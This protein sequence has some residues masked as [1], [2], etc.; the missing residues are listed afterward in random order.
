[1]RATL[2]PGSAPFTADRVSGS[3]MKT[4]TIAPI[5]PGTLAIA[6]DGPTSSLAYKIKLV[7]Q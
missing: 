5:L 2:T 1:M 3:E 6:I 4:Y 7:K